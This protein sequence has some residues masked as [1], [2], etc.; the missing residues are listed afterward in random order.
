M[1][2]HASQSCCGVYLL[3]LGGGRTVVRAGVA[4]FKDVCE[5]VY[6]V[7]NA[8]VIIFNPYAMCMYQLGT[9]LPH[10]S[11]SYMPCHGLAS[12]VAMSLEEMRPCSQP[13]N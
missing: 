11:K 10:H 8:V 12:W 7:S 5:S 13:W 2:N 9:L 6:I 4:P 1:K 3:C